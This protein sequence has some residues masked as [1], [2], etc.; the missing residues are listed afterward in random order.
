MLVRSCFR[1]IQK[2][3]PPFINQKSLKINHINPIKIEIIKKFFKNNHT[4][5]R[6]VCQRCKYPVVRLW[7]AALEWVDVFIAS[8]SELFDQTNVLTEKRGHEVWSCECGECGVKRGRV[9]GSADSWL[10][11][12]QWV[13]VGGG[14]WNGWRAR[15][16]GWEV[17]SGSAARPVSEHLCRHDLLNSS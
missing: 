11:C 15:G 1:C 9:S 16:G 7:Q 6:I 10:H 17:C 8:A 5:W 3:Q 4:S 2:F 13:D 14:G 12:W